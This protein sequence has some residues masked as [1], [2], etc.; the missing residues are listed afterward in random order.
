M[1][2]AEA[3]GVANFT[4]RAFL[5][6]YAAGPPAR[7]GLACDRDAMRATANARHQAHHGK[8]GSER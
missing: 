8:G 5:V 4:R 2:A 7:P 1:H 3:N 6:M